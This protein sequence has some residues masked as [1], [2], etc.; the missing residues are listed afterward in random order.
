MTKWGTKTLTLPGCCLMALAVYNEARTR[1][2]GVCN[3][4]S[5]GTFGSVR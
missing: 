5:N 4:I 2:P 3:T 1:P